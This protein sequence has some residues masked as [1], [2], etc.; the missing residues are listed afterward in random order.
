MAENPMSTVVAVSSRVDPQEFHSVRQ[1][2]VMNM[3]RSRLV[4][5]LLA[6]ALLLGQG[7][8]GPPMQNSDSDATVTAHDATVVEAGFGGGFFFQ[9]I[10]RW[11]RSLFDDHHGDQG[12]IDAGQG[13]IDAGGG[14]GGGDQGSDG[15][16]GIDA[17]QGAIDGG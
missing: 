4:M 16:G 12:G 11:L 6:V 7:L 15:Q 9:K 13:A 1:Q 17:G 3:K 8:S 10:F 14:Q 5:L 2:V